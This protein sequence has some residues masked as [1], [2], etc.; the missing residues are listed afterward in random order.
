MSNTP[1]SQIFKNT[2]YRKYGTDYHAN[3]PISTT[4]DLG[5]YGYFVKGVFLKQGNIT[6]HGFKIEKSNSAKSKSS[7]TSTN[8]PEMQWGVALTASISAFITGGT[9]LSSATTD[10]QE[11]WFEVLDLEHIKIE[12]GGDM[13]KKLIDL[14]KRK[15]WSEKYSIITRISITSHIDV[16]IK[17]KVSSTTKAAL[18]AQGQIEENDYLGKLDMRFKSDE[19]QKVLYKETI[20]NPTVLMLGYS[21]LKC[22]WHF[23][24]PDTQELL[25][26][27]AKQNIFSGNYVPGY[28]EVGAKSKGYCTQGDV[29]ELVSA[30]LHPVSSDITRYV[31]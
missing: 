23:T 28:I 17:E 25:P 8:E 27:H 4:P 19:T 15:I 30:Q 18:G 26:Q 22:K 3:W 9:S 11:V 12:N 10:K 14:T 2:I 13:Q 21:Q 7:F 29:K 5:D 20:E 31:G 24:G 6:Q 16:I 1:I